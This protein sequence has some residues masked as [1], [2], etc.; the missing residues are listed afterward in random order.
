M[1]QITQQLDSN[2]QA[3]GTLQS[4]TVTNSREH[5]NVN[6]VVIRNALE[7]IPIYAKFMK[8][9]ISKKHST[10]IDPI[11]LTEMCSIILQGMKIHVKKKDRGFVTIPCT[12]GD[13]KFKKALINLGSSVSLM[14]LSIYKKL[15]LGT[16]QDTRMTL[17][18]ADRSVRRPYGIVEDVLVKIYK[19]VFSVDFVI[20]EIPEDEEIPLILGIPF[21]ETGRC[22]ID[23]E[24]EQ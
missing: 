22:M 9:I 4:G 15:G 8:D 19:F 5:N 21:L 3:P 23:I 12:I 6:A 11:I 14:P 13:R 18:F 16:V 7:Q 10:N 17:Q 20:L 1:G 24:E 2:S